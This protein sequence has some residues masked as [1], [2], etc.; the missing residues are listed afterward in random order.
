MAITSTDIQQL[1]VAYFGRPADP[2]GL[3]YW[4]QVT[5]AATASG[6]SDDA[7]K[8]SVS[9]TFGGSAEYTANFTGL[10]SDGII[11]RVYLNLFS[12]APD[13]GGLAFWSLKLSSG[14]L[15]L[16]QIVRAVSDS[17]VLA[18]NVDGVAYTS[19]V[20]AAETFTGALDTTT[21]I[22]GYTGAAAGD[23]AKTWISSINDAT[24]L[25]A[26]IT[27][28]ALNTTITAVTDAG[29]VVPGT[30]FTLTTGIDTGAAFIGKSGDDTFNANSV[31]AAGAFNKLDSIDGGAGNNTL[32]IID[33]NLINIT[34]GQAFVKNIQTINITD[35]LT[36][37][38]DTSAFTGLTALN[39]SASNGIDT[40]TAG[41]GTAIS[42]ID[43][44]TGLITVSGGSTQ[45]ISA[46][47]GTGGD[48]IVL[49][50][51]T[52]AISVTTTGVGQKASNILIDDGTTVT[53]A[54]THNQGGLIT[55]GQNSSQT[56]AVVVTTAVD[57]ANTGGLIE[58]TGG[59]TI[60][61]TETATNAA[62]TNVTAESDVTVFGGVETTTVSI[63][64]AAVAAGA[65]AV[66]GV[67]G[68]A[69]VAAVVAAPGTQ[70]V[71]AVTAVNAV[72]AVTAVRGITADGRWRA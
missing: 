22:L 27:T 24:T 10:N 58:I 1:Y 71:A 72:D 50:S 67:V 39:I 34:A 61:V 9:N 23:L 38:L 66:T 36:V 45:T 7:I 46:A 32:N 4:L 70:A 55:I 5:A 21:E 11:N 31:A 68:I 43:T 53:V 52:G 6:S 16:A 19:K 44:A 3:A 12:H 18:A 8:L 26:A 13:P 17:A 20:T 62:G 64:Q 29:N 49:D 25:A 60:T 69:G 40:I 63:T 59:T 30:T 2:T 14:A 56:G 65:A 15:N 33:A 51:A 35:A 42:L 28:T 41:S 54:A 48:N 57:S 47:V 37:T